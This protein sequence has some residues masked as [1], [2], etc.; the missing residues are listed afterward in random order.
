MTGKKITLEQ[1][2]KIALDNRTLEIQLFWQRS[3]Y[4]L[5]LMTALGIGTFTIKDVYLSPIIAAF[6]FL[7]SVLWFNVTVGSKFWQESWEVEVADLSKEYGVRSFNKSTTDVVAQVTSSLKSSPA[8]KKV[9]PVREWV[10]DRTIEK[11]S[12]TYNM[13]LLSMFSSLVWFL[14]FV[15]FIIR[16]IIYLG[17]TTKWC[18]TLPHGT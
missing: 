18:V 12:V 14:V 13:I 10:N 16:L 8:G 2:L 7:C 1:E 15:S 6:A 9:S 17:T 3:N 11:H 4:F 5:V